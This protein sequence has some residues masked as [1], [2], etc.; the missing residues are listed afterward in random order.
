MPDQPHVLGILLVNPVDRRL[1]ADFLKSEGYRV[2][3]PDSGHINSAL[4]G[5]VSLII[6]DILFAHKLRDQIHVLKRDASP[7]FLPLLVLLP[8][9]VDSTP[10]LN[11]GFD[12]V[13]REPL[14]K[15]DLGARLR[16]LLQLREQSLEL[17]RQSQ[18]MFQALVEQSMVGVYIFNR[19]TY[20]YVNDAL[21]QM[22][23][24]RPQEIINKLK[25]LDLVY[26]EDRP[27]V[28]NL[29]EK[30]FLGE[31]QTARYRFRGLRKDGSVKHVEVFGRPVEFRGEV[32]ILGTV[33][34][35]TEQ[36]AAEEKL[37]LYQKE[38]EKLVEQRTVELKETNEDLEAFVYSVSHDLRAPLRG[39]RGLAEALQQDCASNIDQTGKCYLEG[40]TASADYMDMLIEDLL[41]YSKVCR[42]EIQLA[43]VSLERVISDAIALNGHDIR[44]KDAEVTI[45]GDLAEVKGHYSHLVQVFANLISNAIKF[46]PANQRP[47]I[48]IEAKKQKE[49]ILITVSDNGI[50]IEPQNLDRIFK[51]FERLHGIEEYPGTGIGLAIVKRTVEKM[52]GRCGVRSQPGK[53]SQFWVELP[54]PPES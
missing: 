54:T 6:A 25:P 44:S 39:I 14:T 30:R 21:A 1:M 22:A 37:K 11:A 46:V 3:A 40:I 47:T 17:A 7:V 20:I 10:W 23:G 43:P 29:L 12:D 16:V 13:L 52:G 34:D 28:Q 32:V 35:I 33:I 42:S 45:R 19:D 27:L 49:K 2:V 51:L 36:V 38:L 26:P 18:A 50:G 31:L 53:G 41:T 8:P 24:Y 4:R 15:V 9:K 5:G 48:T